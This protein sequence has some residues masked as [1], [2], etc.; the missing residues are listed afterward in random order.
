MLR[1]ATFVDKIFTDN[2]KDCCFKKIFANFLDCDKI[3]VGHE[4]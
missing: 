3:S 1:S 2:R 4:R